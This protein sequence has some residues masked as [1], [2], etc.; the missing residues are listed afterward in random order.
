MVRCAVW[1]LP[2]RNRQGQAWYL[3]VRGR[4]TRPGADVFFLGVLRS[5]V[6]EIGWSVVCCFSVGAR[7]RLVKRGVGCGIARDD[8][9]ARGVGS[10]VLSLIESDGS[11]LASQRL[12]RSVEYSILS[13]FGFCGRDCA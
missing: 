2:G 7:R 3:A 4:R 5:G 10:D 12:W 13:R 1:N 11:A 8:G 6:W 9:H